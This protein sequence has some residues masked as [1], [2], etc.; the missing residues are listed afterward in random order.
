[1]NI[2]LKREEE[3]KI[4]CADDIY[5]I[6]QKVLLRESKI[7][8]NREHLWTISLDTAHRVLNIEL[9]SM[10]SINQVIIEP[11]EVFSVPLQ[12][13]TVRIIIVHNH[14][15]GELKPSAKDKDMTDQLIQ[16]GRI[17]NVPVLDH[18]IITEKT[19]F[20][21]ADS[22]LLQELEQS[23]KYVPEYKI[24]EELKQQL[25]QSIQQKSTE[26]AKRSMAKIMKQN[27][28]PVEKIMQYTGLSKATIQRIKSE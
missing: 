5:S 11:M 21:F 1:M 9:V 22:G 7:D 18:M 27:G 10:G 15:S 8:Q 24:R 17:L 4:L 3:I 6:M 12:K 25:E 19:Y 13:R 28:E 2:R 26:E 16:C 14:P 20:S 23:K